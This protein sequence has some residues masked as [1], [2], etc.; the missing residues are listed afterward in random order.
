LSGNPTHEDDTKKFG[1]TSI[2]LDGD[3]YLTVPNHD[4]WNFHSGSFTIDLWLRT[5][6]T[7]VSNNY[8]IMSHNMSGNDNENWWMLYWSDTYGLQFFC[9]FED[10]T[11]VYVNEG[12]QSGAASTWYHIAVVR[13]GDTWTL[14]RDGVS[15]A[16]TVKSG[17]LLTH[18]G[19]LM[20]GRHHY[21][22]SDEMEAGY[23][24]EIRISKGIA[25]WTS[26]F[27]PPT[28]QYGVKTVISF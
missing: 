4:D 27:T 24:D 7:P 15:L 12:S 8:Y 28:R 3:D 21:S 10:A 13:S 19:L 18:T 6:A 23:L 17:A 26:N 5:I 11:F 16:S 14:Y 22:S 25:R 1:G 20:I 2:Y 9:E